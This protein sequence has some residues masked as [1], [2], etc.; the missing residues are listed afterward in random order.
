MAFIFKL[1]FSISLGYLVSFHPEFMMKDYLTIFK[2][3]Q[4]DWVTLLTYQ[5]LEITMGISLLV[6][7]LNGIINHIDMLYQCVSITDQTSS[8]YLMVS[9][10]S[11]W[12]ISL[13][14]LVDT[15][16]FLNLI[17]W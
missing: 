7:L 8:F 4:T 11:P 16:I 2:S 12:I 5:G 17:N 9:I 6:T 15:K 13:L 3:K 10:I 14:L 1:I